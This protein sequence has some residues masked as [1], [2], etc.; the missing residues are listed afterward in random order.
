MVGPALDGLGDGAG[1]VVDAVLVVG[2]WVGA[3]LLLVPASLSL[4]AVHQPDS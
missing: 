3:A 2:A 4:C 1:V